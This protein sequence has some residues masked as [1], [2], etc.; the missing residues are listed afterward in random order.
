MQVYNTLPLSQVVP[1]Q[2]KEHWH[3]KLT[4]SDR[5]R[6]APLFWQGFGMQASDTYN[7]AFLVQS[8]MLIYILL[9][10]DMNIF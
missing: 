5:T 10:D 4:E 9:R 7:E 8:P 1:I 2:P 3:S 6:H